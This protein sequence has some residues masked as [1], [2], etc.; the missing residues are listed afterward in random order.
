MI[1]RAVGMALALVALGG[2][3]ACAD[4]VEDFYRGKTINLYVGFPPG[5]GYDIYA[6]AVAPYF[7]AQIPGRPVV[8]VRNMEGGSG[9][10]AASYIS[11]VTP[12]DGT[13][14][15]MMLDTTTLGKLLGGPGEFEPAKLKW[16]GRIASTQSVAMVWHTAPAQTIDEARK[17]EII[18]AVT[19]AANSTSMIAT[20]LN[21]LAG[22]KFKI[23][24]GYQGS[25][26]QAL[27]MERG[28]VH[29]I[30]GMSWEAV[31]ATHAHWLREKKARVL[32]SLGAQRLRDAPDAPSLM[33]LADNERARR[34]LGLFASA[35]DIGRS[36]A[37]E[38]AI[39]PDRLQALRRAF[40]VAMRNPELVA[41]MKK[42]S[43]DIDPLAGEEVQKLVEA[44]V[45]TPPD[46]LDAAKRYIQ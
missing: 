13:S 23:I 25:P 20:A 4:P 29:A 30:G 17:T 16:I 37:A 14:L 46:L 32:Y 44:T 27:A 36:F 42:R 10:R 26:P 18:I 35:P 19:Q 7:T 33:D 43:L 28:E 24:R 31:Q 22:T 34:I 11:T 8:T 1:I 6:R 3:A 41:E 38:P 45:A 40:D 9:V 15:A 39:P 2:S 5:G 12:Q 21:D